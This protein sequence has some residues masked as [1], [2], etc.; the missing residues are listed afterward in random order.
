MENCMWHAADWAVKTGD[1]LF[2]PIERKNFYGSIAKVLAKSH[3]HIT[4]RTEKRGLLTLEIHMFNKWG[5]RL[6][7]VGIK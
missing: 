5:F 4:L 2:V 7:N 3:T 6:R 1:E